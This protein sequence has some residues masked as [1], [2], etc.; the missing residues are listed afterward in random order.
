MVLSLLL[1]AE[2]LYTYIVENLL[3]VVIVGSDAG[4]GTFST[5][6]TMI[7]SIIIP[8]KKERNLIY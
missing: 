5:F 2:Y 3:L 8:E 6:G 4:F 7:L 1:Y